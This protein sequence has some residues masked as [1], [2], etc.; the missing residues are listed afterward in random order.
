MKCSV[1]NTQIEGK[2]CNSCGQK[3]DS[4]KL[5]FKTVISDI[6]SNLTDVEKSVFLN[7][8]NI[9]RYPKKVINNYW[10][11]F[12]GYYYKPGKMLFYFITIAGIGA[13]FLK[14]RLFGLI[15]NSEGISE[16]LTFAI[17]FFP[18]LNLSSF[19]TYRRYKRNYLEHL[20]ST[21]Y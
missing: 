7:I 16:A 17:V 5:S 8:Y 18:L 11:G 19:L 13:L 12:R 4:K 9:I 2:F 15:F 20:V 6:F 3:F 14:D 10:D 21:I 1:C